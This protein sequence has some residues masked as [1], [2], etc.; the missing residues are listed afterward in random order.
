VISF[1]D[2]GCS[3][4]GEEK[5]WWLVRFAVTP[6]VKV[7]DEVDQPFWRVHFSVPPWWMGTLF[8]TLISPPARWS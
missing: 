5:S 8:T 7:F 6:C 4:G 1:L 3:N 2:G